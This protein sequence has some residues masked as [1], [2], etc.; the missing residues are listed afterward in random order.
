[1]IRL[2]VDT[3]ANVP[4][5]KRC[6]EE[7]VNSGEFLTTASEETVMLY[8]QNFAVMA[9]AQSS[10]YDLH[11]NPTEQ[12]KESRTIPLPCGPQNSGQRTRTEEDLRIYP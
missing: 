10:V 11:A 1:M 6:A 4:V 7:L 8:T 2:L 5:I 9:Y 3:T 12:R